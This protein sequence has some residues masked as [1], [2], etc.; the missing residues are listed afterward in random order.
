MYALKK[1]GFNAFVIMYIVVEMLGS[2]SQFQR[3]VLIRLYMLSR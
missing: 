3:G 1:T 2:A